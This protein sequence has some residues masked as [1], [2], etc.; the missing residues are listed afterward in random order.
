MGGI[1]IHWATLGI[2][3]IPI[4]LVISAYNIAQCY[5]IHQMPPVFAPNKRYLLCDTINCL[6]CYLAAV[7]LRLIIVIY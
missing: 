6:Q 4:H 5:T 7:S 3:H 2:S 1:V